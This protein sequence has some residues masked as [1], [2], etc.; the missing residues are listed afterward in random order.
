MTEFEKYL[1]LEIEQVEKDQK[2]EDTEYRQ[3]KKYAY[4]TALNAFKK[5]FIHGVVGSKDVQL[6]RDALL[7]SREDT[8]RVR[9]HTAIKQTLEIYCD[10]D[11][12]PTVEEV[13]ERIG[14]KH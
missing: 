6:M 11:E 14:R 4:Y 10:L 2:L 7:K 8:A 9:E 3:G 12:L 5:L 1:K 13:L